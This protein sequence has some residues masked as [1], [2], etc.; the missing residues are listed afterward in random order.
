MVR[1]DAESHGMGMGMGSRSYD[2]RSRDYDRHDSPP[3]RRHSSRERSSR[4]AIKHRST[5][6]TRHAPTDPTSHGLQCADIHTIGACLKFFGLRASCIF[7]FFPDLTTCDSHL[8]PVVWY[9]GH[10]HKAA[11]NWV[12]MRV[13]LADQLADLQP[14]ATSQPEADCKQFMQH[15]L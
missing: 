15:I 11:S 10:E 2:R 12:Q 5:P 4:D 8:N 6:G 14:S 3:R 13:Q 1:D 7:V 9:A